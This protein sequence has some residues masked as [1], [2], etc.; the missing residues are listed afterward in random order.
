MVP[1]LLHCSHTCSVYPVATGLSACVHQ[2][3]H[4]CPS[5]SN[6]AVMRRREEQQL[7]LEEATE[8]GKSWIH[9]VA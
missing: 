7:E 5:Y 9:I 2:A 8:E 4:Q 1:A 3:T 6:V